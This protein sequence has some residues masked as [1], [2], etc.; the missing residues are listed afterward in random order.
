[1][2]PSTKVFATLSLAAAVGQK[3]QDLE[4]DKESDLSVVGKAL[5]DAG[6]TATGLYPYSRFTASKTNQ[7]LDA[8]ESLLNRPLEPPEILSRLIAGLVDIRA[9]CNPERHK[10]I[11]PVISR[12]QKCLDLYSHEPD[13]DA[14]FEDY[15]RWVAS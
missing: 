3:I 6:F 1:M 14:A 12:A 5:Y 13:H 2:T 11:D 9:E 10:I 7:V 4:T 15:K 8:V